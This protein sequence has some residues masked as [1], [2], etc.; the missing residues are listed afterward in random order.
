MEVQAVIRASTGTPIRILD[1]RCRHAAIGTI[2]PRARHGNNRKEPAQ[3]IAPP[4]QR[5]TIFS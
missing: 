1:G 3:T 5:T 2:Q 4:R